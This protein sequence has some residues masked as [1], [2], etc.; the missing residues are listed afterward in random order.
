M[1]AGNKMRFHED[2]EIYLQM[3]RDAYLSVRAIRSTYSIFIPLHSKSKVAKPSP[4]TTLRGCK[5]MKPM[6]VDL[7]EITNPFPPLS[8]VSQL[9]VSWGKIRL[10][11]FYT[12]FIEGVPTYWWTPNLTQPHRVTPI[13]P[14]PALSQFTV[15]RGNIRPYTFYTSFIGCVPPYW[16]TPNLT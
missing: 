12:F 4:T 11:P 2:R 15:S 6:V 1:V 8:L 3:L 14:F 5:T 9:T 13:F 16:W 7:D 10:Y